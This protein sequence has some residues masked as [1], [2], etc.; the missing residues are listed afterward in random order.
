MQNARFSFIQA[1]EYLKK[2]A[3]DQT[4][5]KVTIAQLL[6]NYALAVKQSD[7]KSPVPIAVLTFALSLIEIPFDPSAP[8]IPEQDSQDLLHSTKASCLYYLAR[9]RAAGG[10]DSGDERGATQDAK[11]CIRAL[12][13]VVGKE[14]NESNQELL[15]QSYVFLSTVTAND[16]LALA[17]F[18]RGAQ[19]LREVLSRNPSNET[20]KTQ[21]AALGADADDLEQEDVADE[22]GNVFDLAA[23][24]ERDDS[25]SDE[26]DEEDEEGEEDEDGGEWSDEDED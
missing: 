2:E 12:G 9:F 10:S 13:M 1:V 23:E 25:R 7:K 14:S 26:E 21:L 6:R 16:D 15:G 8:L 22:D 4:L 18:S 11:E 5:L 3:N 20:L 19:I 17:A 24:I